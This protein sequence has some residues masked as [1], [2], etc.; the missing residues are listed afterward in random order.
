[1]RDGSFESD[2]PLQQVWPSRGSSWLPQLTTGNDKRWLCILTDVSS[3]YVVTL[4]PSSMQPVGRTVRRQ[5]YDCISG[6]SCLIMMSSE[7][8]GGARAL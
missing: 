3:V 7:C 4:S 8:E 6:Q 2:V 5:I 1:M